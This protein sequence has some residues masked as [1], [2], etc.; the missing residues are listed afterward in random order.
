MDPYLSRRLITTLTISIVY[1]LVWLILR[2][3]LKLNATKTRL[4][5]LVIMVLLV[6]ALS[7]GWLD[8]L[9]ANLSF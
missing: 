8:G 3:V 2:K 1:S 5:M 4:A 6:L 9:F 7:Q